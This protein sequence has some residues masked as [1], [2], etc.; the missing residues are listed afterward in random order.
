MMFCCHNLLFEQAVCFLERKRAQRLEQCARRPDIGSDIACARGAR[1]LDGSGENLVHACRHP[2]SFRRVRAERVRG[3]HVRARLHVRAVNRRDLVG[4]LQVQQLRQLAGLEP[5]RLEHGAH[6]A[7]EH[8]VRPALEHGAQAVVLHG[9]SG[10]RIVAI[11]CGHGTPL[12]SSS[13]RRSRAAGRR[14]TGTPGPPAAGTASKSPIT[15][16]TLFVG[17]SRFVG[18]TVRPQPHIGAQR[19][20]DGGLRRER[21]VAV[22]RAEPEV[23]HEPALERRGH[24]LVFERV[25]R[26]LHERRARGVVEHGV[27]RLERRQAPQLLLAARA[28]RDGHERHLARAAQVARRWT[29]LRARRS[30]PRAPRAGRRHR[31]KRPPSRAVR[32]GKTAKRP[33]GRRSPSTARRWPRRC[34]LQGRRS[35]LARG[36]PR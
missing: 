17:S 7:V 23:R 32:T 24:D 29:T 22:A 25:R 34:G 9:E 20:H 36:Y 31:A 30:R 35:A 16:V 2:P 8:E 15:A 14:R 27:K 12:L 26:R 3:H 4:M 19:A 21:Q 11:G 10:Q 13:S 1:C 28:E 5:A 33:S 18:S 6:G